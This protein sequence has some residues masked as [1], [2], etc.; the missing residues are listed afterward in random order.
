ML[1]V[2]TSDLE[3]RSCRIDRIDDDLGGKYQRDALL[4]TS[5]LQRW[6][7]H[8]DQDRS[9]GSLID[10]LS[11]CYDELHPLSD[12]VLNIN[13]RLLS[14]PQKL[15][16]QG[17]FLLDMEIYKRSLYACTDEGLFRQEIDWERDDVE[18][19]GAAIKWHDAECLHVSMRYETMNV[20]CGDD[21]LFTTYDGHMHS[22]KKR[23]PSL[24]QT[25]KKSMLSRWIGPDVIN[26]P[27]YDDPVFL[28]SQ[29]QKSPDVKYRQTEVAEIGVEEY[30]LKSEFGERV[31]TV[32]A[33][34]ID[35]TF[36]TEHALFIHTRDDDL[37]SFGIRHHPEEPPELTKAR[38]FGKFGEQILSAH[39][40]HSGQIIESF[41]G[42]LLLT[43]DKKR[44]L[45]T[46]RGKSIRTY[47]RS[48]QF[49]DVVTVTTND[50]IYVLYLIAPQS[51]MVSS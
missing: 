31:R 17:F 39:F 44:E 36:N 50:G 41:D 40:C 46:S 30:Q 38:S 4:I 25:A 43:K 23:R 45:V 47:N 19:R 18:T 3:L 24:K 2:V 12:V 34:S 7:R 22:E 15:G 11:S 35:F 48:V 21:G 10:D 42:V 13:E 27:E 14:T 29:I 49:Q 33:D 20:S 9:R 28:K 1:L 26:Y 32:A 6:R 37:F 5:T 16:M 8:S 51:K